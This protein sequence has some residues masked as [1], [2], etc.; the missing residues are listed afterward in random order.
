MK[1]AVPDGLQRPATQRNIRMAGKSRF[2]F[3][4]AGSST[5]PLA[6]EMA[7]DR[8][9]ELL[10]TR[11]VRDIERDE[12][13]IRQPHVGDDRAIGMVV[14]VKEW[15]GRELE[16]GGP[17]F[18]QLAEL[19]KLVHEISNTFEVGSAAFP[20]FLRSSQPATPKCLVRDHGSI[21][22]RGGSTLSAS[23]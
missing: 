14:E 23:S 15:T 21:R 16:L 6:I 9:E 12:A 13:A 17:R 10:L 1:R 3:G 8:G 5:A 20:R 18:A 22:T 7:L 19:A 4:R 2:S 11:I